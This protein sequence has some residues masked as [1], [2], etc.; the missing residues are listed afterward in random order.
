[1]PFTHVVWSL[2]KTWR[3]NVYKRASETNTLISPLWRLCSIREL[4]AYRSSTYSVVLVHLLVHRSAVVLRNQCKTWRSMDGSTWRM[5]VGA[6]RM[7]VDAW[8]MHLNVLWERITAHALTQ[9]YKYYH[10]YI[11]IYSIHCSFSAGRP[12]YVQFNIFLPTQKKRPTLLLQQHNNA[13]I[14]ATTGPIWS[15]CW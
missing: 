1:M 2:Q 7:H 13:Q 9:T 6:W 4:L 15:Y 11:I 8:R 3:N 10:L 12:H 14:G 5:N